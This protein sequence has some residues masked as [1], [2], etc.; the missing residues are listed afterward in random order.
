MTRSICCVLQIQTLFLCKSQVQFSTRKTSIQYIAKKIC[1]L[2]SDQALFST[3]LF[4]R[5][6]GWAG[7]DIN[8]PNADIPPSIIKTI[9]TF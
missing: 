2:Y 9:P 3:L 8:S 7:A 1:L 4:M 6:T 5:K